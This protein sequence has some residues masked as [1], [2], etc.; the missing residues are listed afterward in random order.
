MKRKR[1]LS[2]LLA[3]VAMAVCC[4]QGVCAVGAA[5]VRLTCSGGWQQVE[6]RWAVPE[7][8]AFFGLLDAGGAHYDWSV[9]KVL[10]DGS[11]APVPMTEPCGVFVRELR[12]EGV[13]VLSLKA[14]PEAQYGQFEVRLRVDGAESAPVY[15]WLLDDSALRDSLAQARPL[16]ANP[17]KRYDQDYISSLRAA[18]AAAEALYT[19]T[20]VTPAEIGA[21]VAALQALA[22]A[23]RLSLTGSGFLNKLA[24]GWWKFT[25]FVTAPLRLLQ[26][27]WNNLFTVVEQVLA[28]AVTF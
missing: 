5:D 17:N 16:A 10:D 7:K 19:A 23:P 27:R 12:Q 11:L 26:N 22:Q 6:I 24:P 13:L 18:I 28:A 14:T 2:I 4:A 25:D 9:R 8:D 1:L 3:V 15:V 20:A 21:R